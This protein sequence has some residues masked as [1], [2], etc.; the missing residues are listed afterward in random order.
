VASLQGHEVI[1]LLSSIATA[2]TIYLTTRKKKVNHASEE[3]VDTEMIDKEVLS[4]LPGD[5]EKKIE[6][7]NDNGTDNS[8]K[9]LHLEKEIVSDVLTQLH[10]AETEGKISYEERIQLIKKYGLE[11]QPLERQINNREMIDIQQGDEH[12]QEELKN[13]FE[14]KFHEIND[15]IN[16]VKK[17]FETLSYNEGHKPGNSP[18]EVL[19]KQEKYHTIKRKTPRKRKKRQKSEA[20]ERIEKIQKDVLQILEQIEEMEI[21]G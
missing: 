21:E 16:N 9:I 11:L 17:D 20:E 1:L 6:I 18:I 4:L 7:R 15:S 2:L 8:F 13:P 14:E 19:P 10:I 5:I 3:T 12:T